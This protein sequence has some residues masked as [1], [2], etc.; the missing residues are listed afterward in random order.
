[1]KYPEESVSSQPRCIG[2]A[3]L[4]VF[5]REVCGTGPT[6]AG[7]ALLRRYVYPSGQRAAFHLNQHANTQFLNTAVCFSCKPEV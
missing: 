1:M 2:K 7:L 4:G 5:P 6:G 3:V